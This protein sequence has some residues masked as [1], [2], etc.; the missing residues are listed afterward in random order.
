MT[1]HSAMRRWWRIWVAGAAVLAVATAACGGSGDP[2]HANDRVAFRANAERAT[3]L[4][5]DAL[6]SHLHS[7]VAV[8]G[9]SY[10]P[11]TAGRSRSFY[12][13]SLTVVAR[14]GT[15]VAQF[16]RLIIPE[17]RKLGWA[18]TVVDVA[19]LHTFGGPVR[20]PIDRIRDG[21][22]FGAVNVLEIAKKTETI[23]FVNTACFTTAGAA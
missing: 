13:D 16:D 8:D 17:L 20:H 4:I 14:A 5:A 7:R 12:S 15:T 1:A 9:G 2:P 10:Q 22:L 18:V 6:V 23:V 21:T 11:C 3:R 19:K